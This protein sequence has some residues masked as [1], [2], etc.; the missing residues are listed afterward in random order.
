M[1]EA[2]MKFWFKAALLVAAALIVP[3]CKSN[4][5]LAAP[6]VVA[7]SPTTVSGV[8]PNILLQFDRPMDVATAGSAGFYGIFKGSSTSTLAFTVDS[9]ALATLNEVRLVPSI[10]LDSGVTYHVYVAGAVK[11]AEGTPLG[12]T[13]HFDFDTSAESNATATTFISWAGATPT[14]GA[15]GEIVLTWPAATGATVGNGTVGPIIANFDIYMSTTDGGEDLFIQ[16]SAAMS[17]QL[18][19]KT[20]SGLVSGTTYFFKI[21]PRDST[22]CVFKDLVQISRVAP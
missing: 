13:I 2:S 10:L 14:D 7:V 22:G 12:N 9:T 6:S 11:S 18:S 20:I 1:M 17:P 5:K 4:A 15:A 21:Q 8:I 19:P 3:A 16:P